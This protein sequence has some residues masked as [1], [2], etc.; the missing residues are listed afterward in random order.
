VPF[1]KTTGKFTCTRRKPSLTGLSYFIQ[2]ST[3]L[4]TGVEPGDWATDGVAAEHVIVDG[5]GQTVEVTLGG[6]KPLTA[7]PLFVRVLAQ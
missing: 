3:T 7:S 6:T 5:D 4:K 1:N 2:T